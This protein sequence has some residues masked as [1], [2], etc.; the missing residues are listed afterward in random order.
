[1]LSFVGLI[2]K[3]DLLFKEPINRSH[4]MLDCY[5]HPNI[6]I[7]YVRTNI[8]LTICIHTEYM[9]GIHVSMKM[10]TLHTNIHMV[11]VRTNIVLTVCIHIEYT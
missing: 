10:A 2:C 3:R 8:L 1:M 9:G 11:Y 4:P 5:I 6:H 7:V